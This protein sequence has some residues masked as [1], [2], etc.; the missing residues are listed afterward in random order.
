MASPNS[1]D[2]KPQ[3][4]V[5]AHEK[6]IRSLSAL[7]LGAPTLFCPEHYGPASERKQPADIA[8][9]AHRC[10]VLM[11][12]TTG[13]KSFEKKNK[14]KFSQ[15]HKWLRHWKLGQNLIGY[16]FGKRHEFSYDEIDHVIGLSIVGGDDVWCE[17]QP[18][19]VRYSFDRKLS[20]CMTL[21]DAAMSALAAMAPSPRDMLFWA[22]ELRQAKSRVSESDFVAKVQALSHYVVEQLEMEFQGLQH[23]RSTHEIVLKEV[24]A[25]VTS[26]RTSPEIQLLT[27]LTSDLMYQDTL[28]LALASSAFE[29]QLAPEVAFQPR[30]AFMHA[31]ANPYRHWYIGSTY[32]VNLQDTIRRSG[33]LESKVPGLALMKSFDFGRGVGGGGL[34]SVTPRTGKSVLEEQAAELRGLVAS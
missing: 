13:K 19:Q 21:T 18:D 20:V 33:Y 1:E 4:P 11:Y 32:M 10:A 26:S 30:A 3:Q 2:C 14:H 12:L 34:F 5:N 8:W 9:V 27:D 23:D 22:N 25:I 17:Y 28:W 31:D 7:I 29:T 6:L 24:G 15:L 16:S